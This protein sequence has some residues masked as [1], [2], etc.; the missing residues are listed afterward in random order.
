[1]HDGVKNARDLIILFTRDYEQS[2]YTRKE[3]T[4]FEAERA[5]SAEER[6]IIVLRCEDAPLRGLLADS[7]Y[8]DLVGIEDAQERK[9]RIIAAAERQ[10]QAASPPPRPFIGVPPRIASFTGR[11]EQLDRL[12]AILMHDKPAA[13]TQASVGRAAVQGMGGVGKTSLAIEYAHRYRNLYAGVCWCPAETRAGLMSVLAN[14]AV[15]QGAARVD[16]GDAEKSAKAALGRLAEQR[17]TW[18][19]VYDNL[20]SPEEIADLLPSAGARVLITSRFSD[21][22]GLADEVPLDVLAPEEAITFLQGR[23]GRSD[24]LGAKTLAETLGHL[25]LALDHAAAYC[26]RTQMRFAEYAARVS[27]L[28]SDLPRGSSYPRSVAAT[29][30]LAISQ[31]VSQCASTEAL[32]AFLAQC[33]P[34]RIPMILVDGAIKDEAERLEALAVL[35]EVSLV[36]HDPFEDCTAAV[37]LHRLVQA[38]ER[39]RSE[40]NGSAHHASER[41]VER[42][43][44]IYPDLTGLS[45]LQPLSAQLTPHLLALHNSCPHVATLPSWPEL[46]SRAGRYFRKRAVYSKALDLFSAALTIRERMLGAEHPDIATNFM[47]LGRVLDDLGDYSK[48]RQV[49][50]R[51]LAIRERVLG[52]EHRETAETLDALAYLMM[53]QGDLAGAEPLFERALA[54]RERVLG[55][56]H[57]D[58][59]WSLLSLGSLLSKKGN[60]TAANP[61]IRRGQDIL[62]LLAKNPETVS[63]VG[64]LNV[65]TILRQQGDLAGAREF[66]DLALELDEKEFGPEHPLIADNL[67]QLGRFLKDQGDIA[68]AKSLFERTLALREKT[69]GPSHPSLATANHNLALLHRDEGDVSAAQPLFE[70]ALTICEEALGPEHP[71]TA[72][73]L[74]DLGVFLAQ[75]GDPAAAQPLFERALAV[76]EKTLGPEHLETARS[77]MHLATL[78]NDQDDYPAAQQLYER[79]LAIREKVLGHEDLDTGHTLHDLGILLAR[80]G[81]PEAGRPLLERALAIFEAGRPS[82]SSD[83]ARVA[84]NLATLLAHQ[85]DFA[86]AQSLFERALNIYE[87]VLGP[88]HPDVETV[89]NALVNLCAE[90]GDYLS[91]QR[92][93]ERMVAINED[94]RGADDPHTNMLRQKLSI[95]LLLNGRPIEALAAGRAALAAHNKSLGLDHALTKASA[96]AT[97]DVL[98][99]IGRADEAK[100]LRERYGISR[101]EESKNT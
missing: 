84:R 92:H 65:A 67:E 31:A 43:T 19:L 86:G 41:L 88:V 9:R 78:L 27:S 29:F 94:V 73:I 93:Y 61:L 66:Y 89:L 35:A 70:R 77:V 3:F 8:Q 13:V 7:V 54:I 85:R 14:L 21:W 87:N 49:Y 38:T 64:A 33:A 17:A 10:S 51:A 99:A 46:L 6:H 80:Q 34:E 95:L 48:A 37:S 23:T 28:I 74:D 55:A 59:G 79:A 52:S 25:P 4:S 96:D 69:L 22:G 91:A 76:R 68:G 1:M 36:T 44:A 58:T 24:P 2:P 15:T 45:R 82:D 12:D 11:G 30:D 72:E 101:T 50:E 98:D 83:T 47:D 81:D 40:A 100:A 18:L 56:Q 42:L 75:H 63:E 62:V 53:G 32:M 5:Q 39:E 90:R 71:N 60:F 16:E 97:A 26:K 20:T 57:F